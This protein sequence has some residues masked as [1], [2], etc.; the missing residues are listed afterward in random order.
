[1]KLKKKNPFFFFCFGTFFSLIKVFWMWMEK[2]FHI[3]SSHIAFCHIKT[4]LQALARTQ[5]ATFSANV[6]LWRCPGVLLSSSCDGKLWILKVERGSFVL[7]Y[8]P[9]SCML[10]FRPLTHCQKCPVSEPQSAF[11]SFSSA[12]TKENLSKGRI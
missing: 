11:H 2:S 3:V 6:Q 12:E 9:G 1:M 4:S 8:P 10:P 7:T 5:S